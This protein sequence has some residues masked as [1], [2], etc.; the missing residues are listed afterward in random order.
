MPKPRLFIFDWDGTL[1]DSERQI[2]QC[3]QM[4]AHD[5][6]LVV[7]PSS[8]VRAI[9]GLGLPEA[10]LKLFPLHDR[11]TR[12]RIRQAYA[13]HFVA[14]AGGRSEMFPGAQ[15]LVLELR[16]R[17]FL[18]AVA[19]GKSRLGLDRVLNQVGWL[20]FF[21]TTRCADETASKPD[22]RMLHEILVSLSVFPAEAVMIG[23]TSFD[24]EM[25]LRA[26]MPSIGVAHGVHDTSILQKHRPLA[27][28]PDLHGLAQYLAS[29]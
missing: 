25:A 17:G 9:I 3:M 27:I 5:L 8:E 1:M 15:E 2:V 7:P 22:P 19:T 11:E 14:E 6:G 12:D 4:A 28:V 20:D 24:L 10:I 23:D 13:R 16:A 21:D 26:N 18:L 29:L